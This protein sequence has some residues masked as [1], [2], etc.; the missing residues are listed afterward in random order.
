MPMR[1]RAAA[2]GCQ[3]GAQWDRP[4]R[5]CDFSY[6]ATAGRHVE[7]YA[8]ATRQTSS[9]QHCTFVKDEGEDAGE[10]NSGT[11]F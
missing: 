3:G 10:I 1:R 11:P 8:S 7:D 4:I 9:V 2:N 6:L 5:T